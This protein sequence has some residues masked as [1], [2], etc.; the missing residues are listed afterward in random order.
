MSEH[1]TA[2][3]S[4]RPSALVV[5][6]DPELR[7][8]LRLLLDQDG[9]EV[10]TAG[11]LAEAKVVVARHRPSVVLVDLRLP[12]GDGTDLVWWLHSDAA[13]ATIPIFVFTGAIDA[14][15]RRAL[16]RCDVVVNEKGRI[17]AAALSA[18][19]ACAVRP[20]SS[21]IS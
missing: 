12:D 15:R 1:W 18:A 19:I 4:R 3:E 20:A 5:E 11:D 8:V 2:T 13:T 17:D 9:V 6:D 14:D 7:S 10:V 21:L 16:E